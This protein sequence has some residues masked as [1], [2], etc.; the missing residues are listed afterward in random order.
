[1]KDLEIIKKELSD[2]ETIQAVANILFAD[3]C[4]FQH[5]V[6]KLE[7]IKSAAERMAAEIEAQSKV[8]YA[9]QELLKDKKNE[10]DRLKA[11]I[12]KRPEIIECKNCKFKKHCNQSILRFNEKDSEDFF[13]KKVLFCSNGQRRESEEGK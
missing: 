7:L 4:N 5:G 2:N 8:G 6:E 1:M 10:I 12:E 9:A 3:L 11:E 13:D